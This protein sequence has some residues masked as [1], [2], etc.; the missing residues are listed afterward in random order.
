M[1]KFR[2]IFIY[3]L[4]IIGT[5][6]ITHEPATNFLSDKLNE[7]VVS[8]VSDYEDST[9]QQ[10]N[11]DYIKSITTS[12]KDDLYYLDITFEN[13]RIEEIVL[14][15]INDYFYDISDITLNYDN[16]LVSIYLKDNITF[17]NNAYYELNFN[18]FVVNDSLIELNFK[19][20]L[21]KQIDQ[22]TIKNSKKAVVSIK[23]VNR[24]SPPTWG[25][26]V[27]IYRTNSFIPRYYDYYVLTN[28]HVVEN[29]SNFSVYYQKSH[30]THTLI[31]VNASLVAKADL[32]TDLALLKFTSLYNIGH[33]SDD[34][35]LNSFVPNEI[36]KGQPVYTIGSPEGNNKNFNAVAEGIILATKVNIRLDDSTTI[37]QDSCQAI[38]TNAVLTKGSSGGG[39]FDA[40][41]NLIGINFAGN[42]DN[43]NASSVPMSIVIEFIK[44]YLNSLLTKKEVQFLD[45]YFFKSLH[46]QLV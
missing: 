34:P 43:T 37:C 40:N 32:N 27:I 31:P 8:S 20:Y 35:Q 10:F 45:F 46:N 2:K 1:R 36:L 18:D 25:S 11:H 7:F 14:L 29:N 3:I 4:V 39:T 15:N 17:D 9:H 24:G 33:L 12:I 23:A 41:G 16:N 38:T 19:T 13:V 26:G 22:L 28:Q 42:E 21:F 6:I 5:F 30:N 44:P